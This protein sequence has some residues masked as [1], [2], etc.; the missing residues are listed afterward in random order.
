[1][2]HQE[3]K[4]EAKKCI[5]T[6]NDG[7]P[8]GSYRVSDSEFCYVHDESKAV[9]RRAANSR[10]GSQTR[11]RASKKKGIEQMQAQFERVLGTVIVPGQDGA[12]DYHTLEDLRFAAMEQIERV[13][14]MLLTG[15]M[16][17]STASGALLQWY[18]FVRLLMLDIGPV[19]IT[20]R[21]QIVEDE[22]YNRE[23]AKKRSKE[24]RG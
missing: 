19:S 15:D 23:V 16:S 22:L 8:C 14:G 11:F 1:M 6:R 7:S 4:I 17:A 21:M 24:G 2:T 12:A 13:K 5:G 10:G 20:D 9:E 18:Q 3:V